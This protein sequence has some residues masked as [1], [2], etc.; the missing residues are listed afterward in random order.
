MGATQRITLS[1]FAGISWTDYREP[2]FLVDP[3]VTRQDRERYIGI[4]VDAQ[5]Y[6]GFG[7]GIRVQYSHTNSTLPNFRTDNFSVSAG[8]TFRF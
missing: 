7:L 2:N 5:L 8:P 3:D 6:K 4:A 1:P